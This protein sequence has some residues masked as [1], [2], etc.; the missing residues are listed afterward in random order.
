VIFSVGIDKY[1]LWI[2]A[3][4]FLP[5][6]WNQINIYRL[7]AGTELSIP[8][9]TLLLTMCLYLV[10]IFAMSCVG[11][12]LIQFVLHK[13]AVVCKFMLRLISWIFGMVFLLE[14]LA[15]LKYGTLAGEGMVA[16]IMATNLREAWEYIYVQSDILTWVYIIF[17]VVV[18]MMIGKVMNKYKLTIMRGWGTFLAI[19][20]AGLVSWIILRTEFSKTTGYR[21]I[22]IKQVAGSVRSVMALT[23]AGSELD[24]HIVDV[25]GSNGATKVILLIGESTNRNHMGIYGYS[26]NTTP[27]MQE[28]I[29][30]GKAIAFSDAVSP[31]ATTMNV[32]KEVLTTHNYEAD[33]PWYQTENIVDI[34]KKAGYESYWLSNQDTVGLYGNL[35]SLFASRCDFAMFTRQQKARETIQNIDNL[36]VE[37]L[38]MLDDYLTTGNSKQFFVLHIMGTHYLYS[39]RYPKDFGEFDARQAA[40]EKEK[41]QN[42]YDNAVLYNDYFVHE[43]YKRIADEDAVIIYIS[44][45]G[46]DV[47]DDGSNIVGHIEE[48][49]NHNMVEI[50]MLIIGSDK[51]KVK[52]LNQWKRML[53]SQ[54]RKF[55]TDDIIHVIMGINEIKTGIYDPVRD[56]TNSNY[57]IR[58]RII[59]GK[60]Y[61]SAIK[62]ID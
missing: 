31:H 5:V 9:H 35:T 47:Y 6:L 36:D 59:N 7:Y 11:I 41:I 44:D 56:I 34:M 2:T 49:V 29:K 54:N 46:E 50:P 24:K 33:V 60:N 45:H 14:S 39:K 30:E 51:F 15:L 38:P 18:G 28:L 21:N 17:V 13:W 32:L 62:K 58:E 43:L 10:Q 4:N 40:S 61:D 25:E 53:A 23:Q 12:M 42:E 19:I 3:F 52:H 27:K 26:R 57:V 48:K 20:V 1:I 37:L 22:P 55:M 8:L 16:A